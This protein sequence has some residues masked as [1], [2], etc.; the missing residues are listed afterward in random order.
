MCPMTKV[1]VVD[2]EPEIV[3][4]LQAFLERRKIY[5]TTAAS[6]HEALAKVAEHEPDIV[7]LDVVMPGID[8]IEVLRRVREMQCGPDVIMLTGH[9]EKD[10]E[11]MQLGAFDYVLK[12]VNLEHLERVL[13]WKAKM[14]V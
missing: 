1:L 3:T 5:V 14:R 4:M 6:G 10:Q 13:W 12:P 9:P 2:D 7:L 11:A 8:G